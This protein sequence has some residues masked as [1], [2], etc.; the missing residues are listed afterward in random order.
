MAGL[1][2]RLVGAVSILLFA[3]GCPI[4]DELDSA[5]EEMDRYSSAEEKR[6]GKPAQVAVKDKKPFYINLWPDDVHSPFWPPVD[7]WGNGKRE[8]YLSVLQEM[9]RQLGKL[10]DAEEPIHAAIQC[11]EGIRQPKLKFV[12]A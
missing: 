3:A 12:P 8:L 10:F 5:N 9:D 6:E 1:T 11:T 2:I 4:M 7:K